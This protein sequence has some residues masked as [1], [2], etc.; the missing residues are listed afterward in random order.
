MIFTHFVYYYFTE[1]I[2]ITYLRRYVHHIPSLNVFWQDNFF[3]MPIFLKCFFGP[4]QQFHRPMLPLF[5]IMLE[6][7]AK[8]HQ[9]RSYRSR[10]I[11]SQ[12]DTK[13]ICSK[14]T[15][16]RTNTLFKIVELKLGLTSVGQ[17]MIPHNNYTFVCTVV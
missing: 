16:R 7:S 13:T 1:F 5:G 8:F 14:Q 10:V 17:W 15:Y 3:T 2:I 11:A 9:F 6:M 4:F 12:T